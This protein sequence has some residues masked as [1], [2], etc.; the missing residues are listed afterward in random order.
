MFSM[1]C[2][3]SENWCPKIGVL[4]FANEVLLSIQKENPVQQ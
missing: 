2:V 4:K 1:L 3:K